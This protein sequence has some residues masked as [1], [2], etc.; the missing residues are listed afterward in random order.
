MINVCYVYGWD[1]EFFVEKLFDFWFYSKVEFIELWRRINS[2]FL[3]KGFYFD[4]V[5]LMVII[6]VRL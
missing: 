4:D 6:V 1:D 5:F 2:N 3:Y